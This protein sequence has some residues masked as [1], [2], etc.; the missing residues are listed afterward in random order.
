M[1]RWPVGTM[2]QLVLRGVAGAARSGAFLVLHVAAGHAVLFPLGLQISLGLFAGIAGLVG[3]TFGLDLFVKRLELR[4]LFGRQTGLAAL[5]G[6]RSSRLGGCGLLAGGCARS[7]G[8][9][10][11]EQ[12]WANHQGTSD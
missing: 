8:T 7:L 11:R 6:C 3:F 4:L 9:V 1:A 2:A 10:L 5:G 12:S